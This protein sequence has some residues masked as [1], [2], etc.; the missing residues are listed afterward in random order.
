MSELPNNPTIVPSSGVPMFR[1]FCQKVLPAVYDDSL[2]YYELLCKITAKINEIIITQNT[3]VDAIKELQS[4]YVEL[5]NYVDN[6]FTNLDVQTE[7][8]NKLDQMAQDGTLA[9]ILANY[10]S[11]FVISTTEELINETSTTKIKNGYII[12]TF[13]FSSINDGGNTK[14]LITNEI[15]ENQ[16]YFTLQN[17]LYGI[18][19]TNK[20]NVL[21]YGIKND[22]ITDN[23]ELLNKIINYTN[24]LYFPEGTYL[25][26]NLNIDNKLNFEIYGD[27]YNSILK[28]NNPNTSSFFY[29]IKMS[30]G[31]NYKCH[32]LKI[33]GNY[34]GSNFSFSFVN[35]SNSII[36][37][38]FV[39][40]AT[41]QRT[42]NL[43]NFDSNYGYNNI[44]RNN[45]VLK[46]NQT[47]NSGALIECTGEL[48]GENNQFLHNTKIINNI[49]ICKCQ[50]YIGDSDLFDCIETDNCYDTLISDNYC[51]TT[52]HHG[53]SLDTRNARTICSNNH[54]I[55]KSTISTSARNGIEITGSYGAELQE[56][57]ISNNII[58]SFA[59]NGISVNA[60]NYS[61]INNR[62]NNSNR[63]IILLE[64]CTDGN[65]ICDNICT[66]ISDYGIYVSGPVAKARILNNNAKIFVGLGNGSQLYI[67]SPVT[68]NNL[69]DGMPRI[70]YINGLFNTDYTQGIQTNGLA[71]NM[72]SDGRLL[73]YNRI[74][75]T[76]Q[77]ITKTNI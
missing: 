54:L 77:S 4:L 6:Y 17:N 37:K 48:S 49:C 68:V 52:M 44:I 15:P 40:G 31:E 29:F 66:N 69:T 65:M 75:K 58:D 34:I 23:T 14:I 38:C 5:K 18:P 42:L 70:E 19:L 24:K 46:D 22:G 41:S 59:S 10:L 1:Y 63:G 47:C 50:E 11:R 30:N 67:T 7:I 32:N 33:D 53:I 55:S 45:Y 12:E 36:E 71:L 28:C 60:I 16:F 8:N 61:V 64:L 74:T 20:E 25:F 39:T 56:G 26:N 62:I 57:I 13:G 76:W 43:Q 72:L 73:V 35:V 27:G 51:E 2:S 21:I 9:E 3:Q